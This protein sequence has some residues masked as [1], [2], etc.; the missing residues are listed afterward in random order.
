MLIAAYEALAKGAVREEFDFA[1]TFNDHKNHRHRL[2]AS[3]IELL[4]RFEDAP[5]HRL[6]TSYVKHFTGFTITDAEDLE[7]NEIPVSS[8]Q[9]LAISGYGTLV[10]AGPLYDHES[11]EHHAL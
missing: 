3:F 10:P 11:K 1:D 8:D 7:R 5:R 9:L 2:T 6:L 4:L